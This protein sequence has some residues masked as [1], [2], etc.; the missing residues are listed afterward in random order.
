M[1]GD[2]IHVV[3]VKNALEIK[4]VQYSYERSLSEK[5]RQGNYL[6]KRTL[7]LPLTNV[8]FE[9]F[10]QESMGFGLDELAD[11]DGT[12]FLVTP[13]WSEEDLKKSVAWSR[14]NLVGKLSDP[15]NGADQ[16]KGALV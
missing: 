10:K 13:E 7:F 9:N 5:D 2:P 1:A 14:C 15:E 6:L 4:L 3:Y 11:V 12:L 8:P 16:I